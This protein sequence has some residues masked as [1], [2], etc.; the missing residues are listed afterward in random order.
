MTEVSKQLKIS[1]P[2]V[3]VAVQKGE[4]LVRDEGLKLEDHLNVNI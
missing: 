3:S 1:L 2:T 4:K